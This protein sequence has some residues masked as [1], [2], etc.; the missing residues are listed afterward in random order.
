MLHVLLHMARHNGAFTSEQIALMLGTNGAVVRRT[1]AGL[2]DAGFVRAEKGHH[3]GWRIGRDLSEITLLDV[4]RSVGTQRL[5]TIGSDN[6]NPTCA[7]EAVVNKAVAETLAN[8]ERQLMER[9]SQ[10]TLADL[11][12]EF[13]ARCV[14]SGWVAD[15]PPSDQQPLD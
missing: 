15:H 14:A 5:F 9:F 3:G 6:D 4:Y 12:A 10:V 13:D 2:R 1:L 8:A 11:S 7:V